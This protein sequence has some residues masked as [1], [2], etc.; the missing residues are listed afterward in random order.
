MSEIS[1]EEFN[2]TMDRLYD[3][4]NTN[5]KEVTEAVLTITTNVAVVK[6]TVDNIQIPKLPDRPCDD[7]KGHVAAHK[8]A[9]E[10]QRKTVYALVVAVAVM[11]IREA[12]LFA[13]NIMG[14]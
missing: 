4:I 7:F 14:N 6:T 12:I 10:G 2:K 1:R 11:I 13:K 8:E 5:H 3:T 9:K